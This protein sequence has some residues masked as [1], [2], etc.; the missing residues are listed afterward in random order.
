LLAGGGLGDAQIFRGA[1]ET[2]RLNHPH[3][4]FHN[5]QSIHATIHSFKE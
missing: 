2:P 1:R 5:A 3:Q 4:Q